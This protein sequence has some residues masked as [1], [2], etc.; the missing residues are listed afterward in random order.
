M[1]CS[2]GISGKY[3]VYRAIDQ[4]GQVI[5]VLVSTRRDTAATAGSSP[6]RCARSR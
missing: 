6:E 3:N 5:D 1:T 2:D 4:H